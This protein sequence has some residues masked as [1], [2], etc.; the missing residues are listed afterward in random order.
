MDAVI[1]DPWST[2]TKGRLL[3]AAA[4]AAEVVENVFLITLGRI[5][6]KHVRAWQ[7]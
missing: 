5:G 4:G 2:D 1:T 7:Y 6:L 3:F